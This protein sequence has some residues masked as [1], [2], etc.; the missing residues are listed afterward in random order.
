MNRGIELLI[1]RMKSNPDEFAPDDYVREGGLRNKWEQLVNNWRHCLTE[2]EL[3]AFQDALKKA[4]RELFSQRVMKHILT[5]GEVHDVVETPKQMPYQH[6]Y[7][8]G[9][10]S[11]QGA[12]TADKLNVGSETLD[13][14]TVRLMKEQ[15]KQYKA[16]GK[17]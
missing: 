12:F 17:I 6:P 5:A 10:T 4:H 1:A 11:A 8:T 15:L 2:E 3:K 16:T 7:N 14:A 13:E 9:I